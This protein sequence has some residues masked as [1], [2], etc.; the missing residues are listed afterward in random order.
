MASTVMRGRGLMGFPLL[1]CM[2]V[3]WSCMRGP[4]LYAVG[5]QAVW[6]IHRQGMLTCMMAWGIAMIA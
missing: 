4:T 3:L 1:P 5:V 2:H 6:R